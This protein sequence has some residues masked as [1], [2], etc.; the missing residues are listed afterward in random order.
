MF[1]CP[2]QR[3]SIQFPG[4]QILVCLAVVCQHSR[5]YLCFVGSEHFEAAS[6]GCGNGLAALEQ[7]RQFLCPFLRHIPGNHQRLL[8]KQGRTCLH[9]SHRGAF[10]H[11]LGTC[12]QNLHNQ[13]SMSSMITLS[14]DLC[15]IPCAD[16]WKNV[17]HLRFSKVKCLSLHRLLR[18]R[19]V[20]DLI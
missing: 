12:E 2:V 14:R 5:D 17:V 4:L 10:P 16:C 9:P 15:N 11:S 8:L 18:P 3:R 6:V 19:P 13:T 7:L 1:L 20:M